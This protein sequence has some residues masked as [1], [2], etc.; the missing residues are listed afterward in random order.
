[1]R[2]HLWQH[3]TTKY[4]YARRPDGKR[5]SLRT[6]DKSEA[7]R[8]AADLERAPKGDTVSDVMEAYLRDKADKPGIAGM[9]DA[10]TQLAGH[11]AHLRPDQI[12][13]STCR[14][15]W[16]RRAGRSNGTI[17]KEL[18]TLRAALRWADPNTPALIQMPSAPQPREVYITKEQFLELLNSKVAQHFRVFLALAWYTAARK[19]A[20][21][22]LTWDRVNLD[23]GFLMYG[24]DIGNKGR[25]SRLPIHPELMPFL[26]EAKEGALT[27]YVV[28]WGRDRVKNIKKAFATAVTRAGLGSVTPHDIRRSAARHMIERGVSMSEV[29][30]LLGHK[31]T[32]V[33]ERHYARFSP[34]YLKKAVEAL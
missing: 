30:Q 1:M 21:L 9:N 24:A 25:A 7:L 6:R 12:T 28:E 23:T 4:W 20:I 17:I 10:W 3:R 16:L 2:L 32:A 31:S 13:R 19:E 5:F 14:E 34:T 11:F 27:N 26:K 29:S 18:S 22:S 33:T 15:Y 8:K